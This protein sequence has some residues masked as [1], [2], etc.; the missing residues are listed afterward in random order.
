[1]DDAYAAAVFIT[2]HGQ[3]AD[4]SHW[5]VLR[6]SDEYSYLANT[7]LRTSDFIR[8]LMSSGVEHSPRSSTP[9]S[10][11]PLRLTLCGW[12]RTFRRVAGPAQCHER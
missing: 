3:V 4:G 5:L 7:A 11:V 10:P 6:N 1:M 12:I 2:G 9:V 8:G